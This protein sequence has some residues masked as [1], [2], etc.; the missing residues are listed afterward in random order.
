MK[1][2][3]VNGAISRFAT[4]EKERKQIYLDWHEEACKEDLKTADFLKGESHRW[5][6]TA[7]YYA[8]L[9]ITKR[10]LA[11]HHNLSI[12]DRSHTAARIALAKVLEEKPE[13]ERAL[14]LLKAAEQEFESFNPK[15][16]TLP[17]M[18]SA[19]QHKREK[20][21]YYSHPPPLHHATDL[22]SFL[23]STVKP[24]ISIMERL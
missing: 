19:G 10:Y 2:L 14:A 17:S 11:K 4:A 9:N 21:S 20:A 23:K 12:N 1:D 13:K 16:K 7:A 24:F 18:L 5:A 22:D 8:M 6:V 3:E 15:G